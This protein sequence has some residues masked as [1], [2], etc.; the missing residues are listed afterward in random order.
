MGFGPTEIMIILGIITLIFG[1]KR[2]PEMGKGLG[3]AI[4]NFRQSFQQINS[5]LESVATSLDEPVV[6]SL[7]EQA[8]PADR[9]RVDLASSR[10]QRGA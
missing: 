7:D 8:K 5:E 6:R 2:L 3:E 1:I 4:V 9:A 10:S